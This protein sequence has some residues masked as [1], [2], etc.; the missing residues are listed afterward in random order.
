MIAPARVA[1]VRD[2]ARAGRRRP[3]R[4]RRGARAARA[5]ARPTTATARWRPRSSTGT[6][7]WRGALDYQLA[8]P[9]RDAARQ[10]RCRR[11]R[12]SAARRLS[13]PPSR[14]RARV[15]VVDDAVELVQAG[16]QVERRRLR[17][18]GAAAR[19]RA[20]AAA[21]PW[22]DR[23]ADDPARPQALA[24][25]LAIVHSHPRWLVERWLDRYGFDDAEA[26]LRFNNDAGAA[27][28]ARQPRCAPRATQLAA[29]LAR[30]GGVRPRRPPI[31]PRRPDRHRR[32]GAV[33]GGLPATG[34]CVV[35]DEASQLV[36]ELAGADAGRRVLDACASP[37]GKTTGARGAVRPTRGSSWPATSGPAH[38]T[39]AR[40]R[41]AVPAPMRR[42][43]SRSDA[44]AP[45]PFAAASFDVVLVDAPCSG[46]GTLRRD[47]DIRWRR[48]AGRSRR[49]SR[50]AQRELLTRRRAAGRAGRPAGLRAPA[51]ASPKRTRTSSTRS[52][53]A[54]PD[55][56]RRA[57]A[58]R[59]PAWHAV[60][61]AGR[62]PRAFLRDR[63][64]RTGSKRSSGRSVLDGAEPSRLYVP[65]IVL[66]M[67]LG[68]RESGAR[69]SCC[70]SPAALLATFL[71]FAGDRH[72]GRG[73]R[74]RGAR[75][76]IWSARPLDEATARGRRPRPASCGSTT[77]RR[78]TAKVP[79]GHV[80]GR[81]RRPGRPRGASAASAS[82]SARAARRASSRSW[83]A[84]PSAPR[85]SG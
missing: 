85:R 60:G 69:A 26:W 36:A 4:P 64:D 7:R 48:R 3:H 73:P 77:T 33:V 83:S 84:K 71:V 22:P 31:A 67:S 65:M 45:L 17:Q 5:T 19:W 37:G 47:P 70:C 30:R 39:A 12:R 53:R 75:C 32:T 15:A 18:R 10:A 63:T 49:R 29:R 41:A 23:P 11:A 27:D 24:E 59:W 52:S 9:Q 38:A 28:A 56:A 66:R 82:G 62:R 21:L 20:S 68:T 51:R 16:G 8:A 78:P 40:H 57:A 43:W 55:F 13:A 58:E 81:S 6:L 46:L 44:T 61:A 34:A 14:P 50:R 54:T 79:A 25:Y 42:A 2:P 80:L 74:A 72:A 1:R 76:L 35:Q